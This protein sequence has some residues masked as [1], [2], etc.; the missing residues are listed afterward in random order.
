MTDR[1]PLRRHLDKLP[2][3]LVPGRDLWPGIAARLDQPDHQTSA[4]RRRLGLGPVSAVG[5]VAAASL[6][7]ALIAGPERQPLAPAT[8]T[9][10]VTSLSEDYALVRADLLQALDQRCDHAQ[11]AC[12]GLRSGLRE[13]DRSATDLQQALRDAPAGSQ[14]ARRLA[15][16]YQRTLEQ[17][18][19]L[20][21]HAARL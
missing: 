10:D 3:D 14:D 16:R 20:A 13:L 7:V 9:V 8:G 18:R 11:V 17:A 21:G 15:A 2:R 4:W 5:L 6:A 1:D 19:G 12:A